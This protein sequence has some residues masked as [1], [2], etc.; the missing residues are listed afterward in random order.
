M[1]HISP[2]T[3]CT[4]AKLL[5]WVS[6]LLVLRQNAEPHSSSTRARKVC[7]EIINFLAFVNK[8]TV[9]PW[10]KSSDRQTLEAHTNR[11]NR[12]LLDI[13]SWLGKES[14]EVVMYSHAQL[15]QYSTVNSKCR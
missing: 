11:T 9:G 8:L 14:H 4:D 3:L 5:I 12:A 15:T 6:L 1:N 13:L 2:H 10:L 7:V